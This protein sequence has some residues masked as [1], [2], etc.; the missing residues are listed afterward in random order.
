MDAGSD[1]PS[2]ADRR[3]PASCRVSPP[4]TLLRYPL[5]DGV[6]AAEGSAGL[7]ASATS[8]ATEHGRRA[9]TLAPNSDRA[10]GRPA[11]RHGRSPQR[12]GAAARRREVS[13]GATFGARAER[14]VW[15][16]FAVDIRKQ[17]QRK[18]EEEEESRPFQRRSPGDASVNARAMSRR[19]QG[20]PQHLS[21]REITRKYTKK[22]PQQRSTPFSYSPLLFLFGGFQRS[23]RK[24]T[25]LGL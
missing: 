3:P 17:Q 9:S 12:T 16:Q 25:I 7:S 8:V 4:P 5:T 11:L 2:E 19:K 20:N 23:V 1:W 13:T 14:S 6:K 22:N 24:I 15:G 18:Q 21:Q 10:P